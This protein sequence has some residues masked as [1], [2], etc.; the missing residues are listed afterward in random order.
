MG[1]LPPR[2]RSALNLSRSLAVFQF[3]RLLFP[4]AKKNC[5]SDPAI[6]KALRLNATLGEGRTTLGTLGWS[7]EWD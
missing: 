1:R 7:Y 6:N 5:S 3:D 4:V 2:V